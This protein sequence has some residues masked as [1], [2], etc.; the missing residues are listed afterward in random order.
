MKTSQ[1]VISINIYIHG[2]HNMQFHCIRPV[3]IVPV[4]KALITK[5]RINSVILILSEMIIY[6]CIK[7]A[8]FEDELKN[9]F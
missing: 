5:F 7:T 9:I 2:G 4:Y 1:N 6:M 8:A 3:N